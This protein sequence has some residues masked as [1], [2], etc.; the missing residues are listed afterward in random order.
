MLIPIVLPPSPLPLFLPL[1][2]QQMLLELEDEAER[3]EYEHHVLSHTHLSSYRRR[4][5]GYPIEDVEKAVED[6]D[7]TLQRVVKIEGEDGALTRETVTDTLDTLLREDLFLL[8][9]KRQGGATS[10]ET[11]A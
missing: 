7:I 10:D 3:I 1:L 4:P 2:L 9:L 5:A 8:P 11:V 6:N